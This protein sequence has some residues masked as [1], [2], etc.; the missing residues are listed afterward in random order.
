M[1]STIT[2]YNSFRK[3]EADGTIDLDSDI[4]NA[5]LLSNGYAVN[6][7][8]SVLADVVANE[9]AAGTGY[10][11][12]GVALANKSVT[13]TGAI[14]KFTADPATWASLTKTFRFL[15]LYALKTA[16]GVTNP[17]ICAFLLDN[18]PADIVV[19]S[20][21]YSVQWNANGIITWS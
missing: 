10:T 18:T 7:A 5:A 2:I 4:I 16:N 3:Y 14:A 17:L 12:G 8:H 11:T 15:V 13:Y 9:V 1:A 19:T 20:A 21:D 6:A